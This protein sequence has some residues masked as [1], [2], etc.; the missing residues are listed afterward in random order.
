MVIVMISIMVLTILAAGLTVFALNV[1]LV[2]LLRAPRRY[3][4]SALAL[5]VHGG[6][7][8]GSWW[9][10][11]LSARSLGWTFVAFGALS[12]WEAMEP[13]PES[14]EACPR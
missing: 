12:A 10:R 3:W 9:A 2:P 13:K 1:T 6:A 14:T 5:L 4:D 7:V 8:T 11:T